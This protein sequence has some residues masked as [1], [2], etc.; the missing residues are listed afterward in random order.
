MK[1]GVAPFVVFVLGGVLCSVPFAWGQ[2]EDTVARLLA[3]RGDLA[4]FSSVLGAVGLKTVLEEPFGTFTVFAP[5][6]AAFDDFK[7][8]SPGTLEKLLTEEDGE[9]LREILAFHIAEG[10]VK[11]GDIS[12]GLQE[13]QM[14]NLDTVTLSGPRSMSEFLESKVFS[15]NGANI[16]DADV[17]ATN[18]V[19]HTI[20]RILIPDE[21]VIPPG[22]F[23]AAVENGNFESLTGAI[24]LVGLEDQLNLPG[25][26][27]VFAP[28][29]AAFAAFTEGVGSDLQGLVLG[30]GGSLEGLI[31]QIL[32]YHVV[33]NAALTSEDLV[34]QEE[35][36]LQ[37][38]GGALPFSVRDG[39]IFV[40]GVPLS[41]TDIIGSNGVIHAID[42]R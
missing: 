39:T 16:I 4:D 42:G 10:T 32:G 24:R 8:Y 28:T 17:I 33:P 1:S 35:G 31:G 26:F 21:I 40:G 22:I 14:L 19:V 9:V 3:G 30:G 41:Q 34:A 6:Q 25:S 2:K 27:T 20:D 12:G 13:L 18:G 15:V 29:D 7:S 23:A 5:N 38:L 36:S 37:T 11:M